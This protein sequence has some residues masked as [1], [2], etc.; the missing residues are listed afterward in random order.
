MKSYRREEIIIYPHCD[1][2]PESTPSTTK[3][4]RT[5]CNSLLVREY[6]ILEIFDDINFRRTILTLFDFN[7]VLC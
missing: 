3:Q 7:P 5:P 4:D 1:L 6:Y 2:S